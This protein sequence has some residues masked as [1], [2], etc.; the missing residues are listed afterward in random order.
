[1]PAASAPRR[2]SPVTSCPKPL[3]IPSHADLIFLLCRLSFNTAE[4]M[5]SICVRVFTLSSTFSTPPVQED[6]A[7]ARGNVEEDD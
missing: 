6:D 7:G 1:M 3:V 5:A 2:R 4:Q